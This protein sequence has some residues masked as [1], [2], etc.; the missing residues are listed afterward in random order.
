VIDKLLNQHQ[1]LRRFGTE[2]LALTEG[3]T[4]CDMERLAASRWRLARML[5]QHLALEER[6]IYRPLERDPRPAAVIVA[7]GFRCELERTFERY[8]AHMGFWTREKIEK[9]WRSYT[10]AVG[11]MVTF[12]MERQDREE[13]EL[14]PLVN[15]DADI[16]IRT[17]ADRNWA[18]GGWT[19][20]DQIEQA[21]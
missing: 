2:L 1:L 3:D 5:L 17:P 19:I 6:V 16:S 10:L 14:Y 11:H 15:A 12:L 21:A 13:A 9:D 7:Q 4:P 8:R 20:R 18:A